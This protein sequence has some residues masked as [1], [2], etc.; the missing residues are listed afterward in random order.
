M[1]KSFYRA[2]IIR[3]LQLIET[4]KTPKTL[5]TSRF[6]GFFGLRAMGAL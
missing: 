4:N 1:A 3:N 2:Q 5:E 6:R